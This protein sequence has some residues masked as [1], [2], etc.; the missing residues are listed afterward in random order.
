MRHGQADHNV[1]GTFNSRPS[2]KNYI[3]SHLT[4]KGKEQ[5][6]QTSQ[7]LKSV[8]LADANVRIIYV[9]PLPRAQETA[10]LLAKQLNISPEKIHSSEAI[11]EVNMGDYENQLESDFV[12]KFGE[13][14][15]SQAHSYNGETNEDVAK[16]TTEFINGIL[17]ECKKDTNVVVIT[18][19]TPSQLILQYVEGQKKDEIKTGGYVWIPWEKLYQLPDAP[20]CN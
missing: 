8:G 15:Y 19:G 18:H 9:S 7:Q 17:R 16:R 13:D 4:E 11:I 3:P 14:N 1:S 20:H 10:N 2:N 5:V 6:E 12:Q